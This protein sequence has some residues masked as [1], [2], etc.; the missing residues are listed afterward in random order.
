MVLTFE[1]CEL[2]VLCPDVVVS[3]TKLKH[4]LKF[5]KHNK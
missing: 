2:P 1:L 5:L 3:N 4:L